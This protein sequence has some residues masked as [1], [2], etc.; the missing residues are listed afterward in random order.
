MSA[1]AVALDATFVLASKRVSR[2]EVSARNF[3]RGIYETDCKADELLL[4]VRFPIARKDEVFGFG[5]ISRRR[6]DFAL[7]GVAARASMAQRKIVTLD[8]V[9]FG[10]EP[11]PMLS[12]R[13]ASIAN[14]EELTPALIINL[15]EA[16]SDESNPMESRDGEAD[17]R[18]FQTKTIV[19]RVLTD[20]M[21]RS[22]V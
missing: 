12:A 16:I 1:C 17:V 9:V 7:V 20:V 13:T 8:L 14:G 11:K 10:S 2:R 15:S 22:F 5:E 6:G 3:F 21:E 19:R 18:R 4:E